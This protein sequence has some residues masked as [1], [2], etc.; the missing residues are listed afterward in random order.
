VA[1][2]DDALDVLAA[3]ADDDR[4]RVAAAVVLGNTGSDAVAAAVGLPKRRVLEALTRLEAAGV[5]RRDDAGD[6]HFDIELLREIARDARPRDAPDDV[7]DVDR[8]TAAVLR[9]FLRGGR[10]TQIPTQRT[11]RLVVLDHI[12]RVFDIGVRYSEKEVNT[13]L[14]A[15]HPD[16]A[17]LR[18]YLVDEGFLSRDHN[19]Y[20]RT[21]GGVEV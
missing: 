9:T 11:K 7:G 13:F 4:I 5:V 20:W 21:G 8:E 10:L 1:D 16:T 3:L 19:V 12:C 14:R 17:A 2:A 6:W 15:F 18:R